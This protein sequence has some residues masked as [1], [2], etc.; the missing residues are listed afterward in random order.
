MMADGAKGVLEPYKVR[1][2][3]VCSSTNTMLNRISIPLENTIKGDIRCKIPF[4]MVLEHKCVLAVC[5]HNHPI[6][7]KNPPS[8]FL[9]YF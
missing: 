3:N 9:F 7:I 8:A 2:T 1:M 6:V 5:V 4:Y